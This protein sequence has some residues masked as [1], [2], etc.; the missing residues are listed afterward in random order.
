MKIKK[1]DIDENHYKYIIECTKEDYDIKRSCRRC[2][3]K[4]DQ[5]EVNYYC[6]EFKW[7]FCKKCELAPNY[8]KC[9]QKKMEHI[10]H[11]IVEWVVKK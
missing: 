11:K 8:F 3:N 5:T 7:W 6:Q 1:I 2:R 10:H 4:I 9:P